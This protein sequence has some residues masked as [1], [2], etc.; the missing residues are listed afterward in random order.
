MFMR[1]ICF[2]LLLLRLL[3]STAAPLLGDE[4]ERPQRVKGPYQNNSVVPKNWFQDGACK[5]ED[6]IEENSGTCLW[7]KNCG[8]ECAPYANSG[9]QEWNDELD[10]ACLIHDICLCD[11]RTVAARRQCDRDLQNKARSIAEE[12]DQCT[13][14]NNLNLFCVNDDIVCAAYNVEQAMALF[15]SGDDIK[16]DCYV[17][18]MVQS[19]SLP[20]LDTSGISNSPYNYEPGLSSS[21][22]SAWQQLLIVMLISAAM[23]CW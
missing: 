21:A 18:Q 19:E 10:E 1:K 23:I 17:N 2:P 22:S 5:I 16:N 6:A 4:A 15:G 13:G 8:S 14:L 20:E 11:A 3:G 9:L 12:N 7:G